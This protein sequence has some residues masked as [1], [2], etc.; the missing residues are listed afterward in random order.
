MRDAL[1]YFLYNTVVWL[2]S[3]LSWSVYFVRLWWRGR[4]LRGFGERLGF[5]PSLPP[6]GE[7]G[8]IWIHA[9][10]VGEVGVAAALLPALRARRPELRV[11]LSTVTETGREAAA[12]LSGPEAL[13]YLPFDY[14]FAVRRALARLRPCALVVVETELWPNLIREA[15]RRGIPV[16]VANGRLSERSFRRYRRLGF[17]FQRVTGLLAGVAAREEADAARFRALGAGRVSVAGNLKYD[18][19]APPRGADP[20]AARR[21]FG[22]EG[23]EP[24]IVA[25]STHPGEEAAVGRAVRSLRGQL[26]GL[27]LLLAPRRLE[28]VDEVEEILR[29]AGLSPLR[30]S[31]LQDG[32]GG[33]VADRAAKEGGVVI[34]DAM[35]RLA[36]AYECA[37]AAF[38]GGSLIPHGGQNPIEA[39]R[40]GVPL[41]FGPHMSN[42]AEVAE[43]LLQAGGA[44]RVEGE[45]ALAEALLPWLSGAAAR[46]AAGEAALAAVEANRGA[47][48]RTAAILEEVLA[49]PGRA[50]P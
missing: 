49:L 1:L 40:W 38:I 48:S 14:P 21:R 13:F 20:P 41:V 39:A 16:A 32:D 17:L 37:T 50:G 26:P 25:G 43:G 34:L 15:A 5:V 45:G 33:A 29:E 47:A 42:F 28:R 11:V 22:L 24:V 12:K 27:G 18:A 8:R 46:K 36:E 7:G 3:P 2:L 44:I 30:W 9:V 35:G 31:R 23:W 6:P 10:S 19:P 4:S